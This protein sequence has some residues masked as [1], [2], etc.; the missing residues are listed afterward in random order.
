MPSLLSPKVQA[1]AFPA[2]SPQR[3]RAPDE[4]AAGTPRKLRNDLIA[5]LGAECVLSRPIDIIR[6]ATDA[7]PY[8]LF[9]KVVVIA[10]NVDDVRKVLRY[11]REN[12]E[13][14]TFRA[15]GTSL[16]GQAQGDG[17][18]V[19]VRRYWSGATVEANGQRLRVRP[20]TILARANLALLAHGYRLGPDP[21]S[22]SACTIGGVIANNS[23]G[24]CCGITQNAYKT[25]SSLSF[26]LP[27]GT[28]IDSARDDA[29]QQ[30]VAAEPA[31]AA[32]L[33][34]IKREIE[35][36]PNS[37]RDCARSSVSRIPPATTWRRFSTA[38]PRFKFSAAWWS[39]PRARWR[40]SPRPC[41][42][43]RRMIN[44]G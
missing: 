8:R 13:T 17:I 44:T 27:S 25:L 2:S 9:P 35:A 32:G 20:G 31:L 43:P 4:L 28:F 41:S 36:D 33:M 24:M 7:S 26:M 21:A 22:A 42:R 37:R 16:S 6:F 40:S 23:S 3:D 1:I 34:E 12:G 18:L 39:A 5:L 19:D 29:E 11:A 14:V 15:A 38:E 30:F 10:H